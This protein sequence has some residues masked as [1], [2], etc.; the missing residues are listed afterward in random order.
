MLVRGG[1]LLD[2]DGERRGDL[3][4]GADGRI[5]AA[6][7]LEALDGEEVVDATGLLVVPGGVDAHTHLH[8]PVGNVRVSDDFETGTAAAAVGGTTTII[9]Y[10]TAYR[11]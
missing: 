7:L 10:V 4:I 9:D 8:L 11:G 6:G 5:A 2:L 1:S 3:R